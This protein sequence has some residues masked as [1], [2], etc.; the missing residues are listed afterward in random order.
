ME[1]DRH[2]F[3]VLTG[4]P[5]GKIPLERPM[6]GCEDNIRIDFKEIG[7][8]NKSNWDD[9]AQDMDYW[10]VLVNVVLNLRVS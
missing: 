4:K 10:K 7:S 5:T 6:F 3:K 2:A 8:T 9:S 1:E